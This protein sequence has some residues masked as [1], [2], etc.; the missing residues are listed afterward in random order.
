MV[1]VA[2]AGSCC[3]QNITSHICLVRRLKVEKCR[4]DRMSPAM[5]RKKWMSCRLA[6]CSILCAQPPLRTGRRGCRDCARAA[7]LHRT[8]VP[9]EQSPLEDNDDCCWPTFAVAALDADV[10]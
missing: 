9:L 10:A 6:H 4:R 2:A 3:Y 7:S 1:V 8:M 5:S